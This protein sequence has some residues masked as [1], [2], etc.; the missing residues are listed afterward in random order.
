MARRAAPTHRRAAVSARPKRPPQIT[1]QRRA[2]EA[3]VEELRWLQPIDEVVHQ[4]VK[5]VRS[6]LDTTWCS[7]L[8]SDPAHGRLGLA[9]IEGSAPAPITSISFDDPQLAAV[10][11]ADRP[12]RVPPT[13]PWRNWRER[14]IDVALPLVEHD[15]WVGLILVGAQRDAWSRS[16][17]T[18][19]DTLRERA[20]VAIENARRYSVAIQSRNDLAAVFE[21]SLVASSLLDLSSALERLASHITHA[22]G[23]DGATLSAWDRDRDQLINWLGYRRTSFG[24]ADTLGSIVPLSDLPAARVAMLDRHPTVISSLYAPAYPAETQ[25]LARYDIAQMLLLPLVARDSVIGLMRLYTLDLARTF[26][27]IELQLAQT[28]C[29]QAAVSIDN[30]R[31][32]EELREAARTLE[33]K[34]QARTEELERAMRNQQVEASKTLAI[35]ESVNDGVVVVDPSGTLT[36]VNTAAESSLGR[37]RDRLIG[38]HVSE[39]EGVLGDAVLPWVC[40]MQQWLD[41]ATAHGETIELGQRTISVIL[42]PVHLGRQAQGLVSVLRDITR[43]VEINR[44]KSEFVS[45]VSHELRTPMTSLKGYAELLLSD[46]VGPL[47][48][49]QRQFLTIIRNN[50]ERLIELV[51]DLLD[52]SRIETGRLEL[53]P[54]PVQLSAY[55]NV[56]VETLRVRGDEKQHVIEIA[57][58]D[59]LPLVRADANRLTQI[60]TNLMGNAIAYTPPGGRI[61]VSAHADDLFAVIQV[62]DSGI[63]IAPAD[64]QRIFERFYRVDHPMV[65]QAIGTGL[66]LPIVRSLVEMHGGRVWLHS[67]VG[68][69]TTF[70]FT[71]P[72]WEAEAEELPEAA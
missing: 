15:R 7:L 64:Q 31:L 43:E 46:V 63:G 48:D 26:E 24:P 18:L 9:R 4:I 53:K 5:R 23:M 27:A 36:L 2:L 10:R 6:G 20:G 44:A 50:V 41:D 66:G 35:I 68:H 52:I 56:V 65:R 55:V 57:V 19:L 13:E 16:D 45:I 61:R 29:A 32:F 71:L 12:F 33:R 8:L 67:E 34:V 51:N 11:Q 58:P 30:A 69:G 42:S 47:T 59:T 3:F 14:G 21:V 72:V 70:F 60:L 22:L 40:A 17:L 49:T 39:L 28:L 37:P 25:W 38:L 54:M 1:D 62:S